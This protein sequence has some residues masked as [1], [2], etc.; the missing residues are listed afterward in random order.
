M[1][2][3]AVNLTKS[4]S[5]LLVKI[6]SV[7]EK[8][9]T[10][11]II[12]TI[13]A[14]E[15]LALIT[16]VI[17]ILLSKKIRIFQ[18]YILCKNLLEAVFFIIGIS[19]FYRV[20]LN[21][22]TVEANLTYEQVAY[23]LYIN[24]FLLR[25]ILQ[26]MVTFNI[27]LLLNRLSVLIEKKKSIFLSLKAQFIIGIILFTAT[28]ASMPLW[29]LTKIQKSGIYYTF[30]VSSN[31]TVAVYIIALT[32]YEFFIPIALTCWLLFLTNKSYK[33]RK[34]LQINRL[35]K[36]DITYTKFVRYVGY[37]NIVYRAIDLMGSLTPRF[38]SFFKDDSDSVLLSFSSFMRVL[39]TFF[40]FFFVLVSN[41]IYIYFEK[42]NLRN[43]I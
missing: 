20:C 27:F 18:R 41:L 10:L 38:L 7:T 28:F 19:F 39:S 6:F 43:Y 11:Y 8:V 22:A 42:K 26:G 13:S 17:L 33:K 32:A 9:L 35:K 12:P 21:C 14:F 24:T 15:I 3:T 16:I 2:T 36:R 40:V 29:F 23:S 31:S 34:L 1:N 4:R 37:I 25:I 30:N 5:G